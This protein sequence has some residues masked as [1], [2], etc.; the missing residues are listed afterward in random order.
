MKW[1]VNHITLKFNLD[2]ISR[3]HIHG[4]PPRF[5]YGSNFSDDHGNANFASSIR[6]HNV[7]ATSFD[8]LAKD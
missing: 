3:L 7:V 5:H 4:S 1:K 6:M 2:I 8:V